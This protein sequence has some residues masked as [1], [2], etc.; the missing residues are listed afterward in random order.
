MSDQDRDADQP[1]RQRIFNAPWQ[2]LAV[3]AG[4]TGD[5]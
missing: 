5:A 2:V 4:V 1:Q 3:V